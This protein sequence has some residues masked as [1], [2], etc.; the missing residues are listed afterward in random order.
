MSDIYPEEVL[1][2]AE[3]RIFLDGFEKLAREVLAE[4]LHPG[5]AVFGAFYERNRLLFGAYYNG[6][7]IL[8]LP[9]GKSMLPLGDV[10]GPP[11]RELLQRL[12][13]LDS[14]EPETSQ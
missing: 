2:D 5:R 12:R 14:E 1:Q 13:S 3:A 11:I 9:V 6:E 4:K 8:S 10:I 7:C